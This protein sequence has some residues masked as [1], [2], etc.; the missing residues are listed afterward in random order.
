MIRSAVS[1]G[2]LPKLSD[3]LNWLPIDVVARVV[4]ELCHSREHRDVYHVVNPKSFNWSADLLP[5]LRNAGLDFEPVTPQEWL[6]RLASSDPDPAVN[7]T[8]KLLE[9]FKTKYAVS[10]RGPAVKF[11]TDTTERESQTLRTVGAPDAALIGK[12]VEFWKT[13]GWQ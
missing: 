5:M 9:F 2:A 11:E 7:P 13:E 1:M 8:I 3:T 4:A 6:E 10:N 12:M